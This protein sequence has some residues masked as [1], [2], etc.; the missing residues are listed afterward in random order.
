[1]NK[2][3]EGKT[4]PKAEED[5]ARLDGVSASSVSSEQAIHLDFNWE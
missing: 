5:P 1:M 3:S 2:F 4:S